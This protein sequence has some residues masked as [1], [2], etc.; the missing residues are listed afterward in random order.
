MKEKRIRSV[1]T[2]K[3]GIFFITIIILL[4]FLNFSLS[5]NAIEND[6]SVSVSEGDIDKLVE[7]IMEKGRIPGAAIVL[8]QGNNYELVKG[9]GFADTLSKKKVTTKTLFELGSCSKNFTAVGILRLVKEG[10]VKLND[11]ISKYFPWFQAYFR[12]KTYKITINQLLHHI[13]GI[14]WRTFTQIHQN[15]DNDALRRVV[16]N[17]SGLNLAQV[18]GR[19]FIYSNTDYDILGAIIEQAAGMKFEDFMEKKVFKPLGL[20]HTFIGVANENSLAAKGHKI[21]FGNVSPFESPVY[22]G[23]FPAGY[24]VSNAGDVARWLKIQMGLVETELNDVIEKYREPNPLMQDRYNSQKYSMGWFTQTGANRTFWHSGLNPNFSAYLAFNPHKKMAVAVLA[25]SNSNG[26]TFL[27]ERLMELS[28]GN[29]QQKKVDDYEYDAGLDG[30]FS[31]GVYIFGSLL[32]VVLGLMVYILFDILRGIRTFE[33]FGLKK[34]LQ[35]LI[36]LAGTFPLV[37]GI[38]FIPDAT[39]GFLWQDALVWT[40]GSF[41]TA[42]ILLLL[43]LASINALFFLSLIFPYK[44]RDSFKNKYIKPLPLILFLGFIS[45]IAN[46]AAM[47]LISTSF[48]TP[49]HLKYLLY[50]FATALFIYILGQKIVQTKMIK[51]ANNIVYELRMRLIGKIF[52]TRFQYFEKIDS[53]RIFATINNDT[54]TISNSAGMVVGI[55][56]NLITAIAAFA[57][58]SAISLPATLATLIFSVLLGIFYIIVGKKARVLMEK[59]RDTQN[60]FMKLVEGLV[61]GF[62]E[63]SLHHNKKNEYEADVE[64]SCDEYRQTRVSSSVKFVNANLVSSSMIL[65]LLAVICISFPRIFPDMSIPRLISFIMVLLYMIGPVTG[66]MGSFPAFIRIKVSWDRIQKFIAEIPAI[67]ELKEYRIPKALSY[68]SRIVDNLDA[69]GL[70]FQYPGENDSPG[71]SVG[72]IDLHVRKGEILFVVGGNGSGKTTLAML[73]TG[74]YKPDKGSIKINGKEIEGNDYLGE[75]FST[76]FGDFHLF[77]KLYNV[78]IEEKRPEIEKYLQ[79]LNLQGKVELKDG[80]FSTLNL[81]GGQKKRLALLQCYLE[82][83]PIY[84]FDEVAADQDPEFRKFFYRE[85]L[86][87]MKENGKIVIAITH[88]DHYFDVADQ[89]IKLDMGKLDSKSR[90][91]SKSIPEKIPDNET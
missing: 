25:N 53:G 40:P 56:T 57:Y 90:S 30:V 32:F 59:M 28:D 81:S 70:F 37:L 50:Y 1:P 91:T 78:D 14:P 48:F 74:L 33:P 73:L 45:G 47:I 27:G 72:P 6:G 63:I 12:G 76:V 2:K 44:D 11:P 54:E 61:K 71:F 77:Q 23:N 64:K 21:G 51:I 58:L 82:D 43:F 38:Y 55:I 8:I 36:A 4:F 29:F 49:L 52:S 80:S 17:V 41:P 86:I 9:Y 5:L 83:C 7:T 66:I 42:L 15:R 3:I 24:V 13:G 84:L 35:V 16:R 62:K 18:P 88:D 68:K 87:R 31:I 67:P 22:R 34:L 89:I 39:L 60:V 69:E 20:S 65:T 79:I 19:K 10:W 85:L 75:Y 26:S 46:S